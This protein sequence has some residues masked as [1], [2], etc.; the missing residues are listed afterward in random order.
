MQFFTQIVDFF[1]AIPKAE[2]VSSHT[3]FPLSLSPTTK[4]I[5]LKRKSPVKFIESL[6]ME[7]IAANSNI[8]IVNTST[9]TDHQ[10]NKTLRYAKL[11]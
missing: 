7:I 4:E 10:P 1:L 8:Y 6:W 2:I 3:F 11:Y 5:S 9:R